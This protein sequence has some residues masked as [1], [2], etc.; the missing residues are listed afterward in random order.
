MNKKKAIKRIIYTA[1]G[2]FSLALLLGWLDDTY[3]L[4][5]SYDLT[6]MLMQ[7]F[8][9]FSLSLIVISFILLP[10][11]EET[12]FAWKKFAKIYLPIAF[13]IILLFAFSSGGGGNWGLGGG[14]DTEG[15]TIFLS[16]LFFLISLILIVYKSWKLRKGETG[17][18]KT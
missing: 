2:F 1:L 12:F 9:L 3:E 4:Y 8:A 17:I 16:G 14:M 7:T 15:V 11:R 10:L 18:A 5:F 13:A 6:E